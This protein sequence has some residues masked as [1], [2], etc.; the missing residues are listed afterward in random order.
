MKAC[1]RMAASRSP[2]LSPL[3]ALSR[4]RA[5]CSLSKTFNSLNSRFSLLSL[6]LTLIGVQNTLVNHCE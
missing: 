2:S 5:K 6:S 1:F 3:S 4:L